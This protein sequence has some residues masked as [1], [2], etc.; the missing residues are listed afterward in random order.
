MNG[1]EDSELRGIKISLESLF[2]SK[3]K[4][5]VVR[6]N[7]RASRNEHSRDKYVAE[8]K[9]NPTPGV[10]SYLEITAIYADPTPNY[11]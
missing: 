1:Q 4:P 9:R 7:I 2:F 8:I 6:S 3:S 10:Q 11:F 5:H